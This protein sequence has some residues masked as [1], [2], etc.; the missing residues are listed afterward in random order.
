MNTDTW[1]NTTEAAKLVGLHPQTVRQKAAAGLIG[2]RQDTPG[3]PYKFTVADCKAYNA[4]NHN[5]PLTPRERLL[6]RGRRTA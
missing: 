6:G 4:T 2:C 3:G 5:A 1:L